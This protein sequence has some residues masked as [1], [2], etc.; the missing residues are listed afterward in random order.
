MKAMKKW[1][2]S[3]VTMKLDAL[4]DRNKEEVFQDIMKE[5]KA[6]PKKPLKHLKRFS[7]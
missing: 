7:S 2:L 4:P 6:E 3:E 1:N 5:I